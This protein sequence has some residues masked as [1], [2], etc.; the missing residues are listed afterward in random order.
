VRFAGV[1]TCAETGSCFDMTK[2]SAKWPAPGSHSSGARAPKEEAASSSAASSSSPSGSHHFLRKGEGTGGTFDV[3]LAS[4]AKHRRALGATATGSAPPMSGATKRRA[5]PPNTELRRAY[6]RGDLPLSILQGVHNRLM[7]KMEIDKL[8]LQFYLPLFC[9]GLRE[10][11]QP[12]RFIAEEGV[13]DLLLHSPQAKILATIPLI[14]LPLKNALNTR[15]PRVIKR[16]LKVLQTLVECGDLI[17]EALVPYYRQLLPV[18]S[19]FKSKKKNLGD[20]MDYKPDDGIGELIDETLEKLE[21]TGGPD[22]FV[23]IKYLVSAANAPRMMGPLDDCV[24]RSRRTRAVCTE[25][26]MPIAM[27]IPS[28]AS[29]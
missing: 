27:P 20:A 8:D 4:T 14:I 17:G 2:T 19:I 12:Y 10:V 26:G 25:C 9:D 6:E 3:G 5:N 21:V 7:W 11:E 22:A 23:N 13:Y 16:I 18:L 29:I 1:K 24:R 15:E 28:V